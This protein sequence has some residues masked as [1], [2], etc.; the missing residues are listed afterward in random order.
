M[1]VQWISV[2]FHEGA[3]SVPR[4]PFGAAYR[5]QM[6]P[7]SLTRFG[8]RALCVGRVQCQCEFTVENLFEPFVAE[9][10]LVVFLSIL[11]KS[12]IFSFP[13][14]TIDF[15]HLRRGFGFRLSTGPHR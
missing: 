14:G 3:I 5:Q 11:R 12:E 9:P 10:I 7:C 4:V 2:W 1:D 6:K 13:W 8:V 15:S